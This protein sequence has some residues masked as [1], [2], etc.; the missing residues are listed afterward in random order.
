MKNILALLIILFI[1]ACSSTKTTALKQTNQGYA[2]N[3]I[4]DGSIS[5]SR[6]MP[7]ITVISEP[8][9]LSFMPVEYDNYW[10]NV[11]L[12]EK[13]LTLMRGTTPVLMAP[14]EVSKLKKGKFNIILKEHHPLWHAS[15]QYFINRDLLVPAPYSED[16]FLKS[17]LGKYAIYTDSGVTIHSGSINLESA[18]KLSENNLA[19]LFANLTPD[20]MVVIE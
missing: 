18:I 8:T 19:M 14:G 6:P 16:R 11:S 17:A 12:E 2:A 4:I 5:I 1:S 7:Q 3:W 15:D 9:A 10:L 13:T 20:S